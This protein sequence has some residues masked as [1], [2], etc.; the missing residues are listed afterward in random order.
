MHLRYCLRSHRQPRPD[1][2]HRMECSKGYL[3]ARRSVSNCDSMESQDVYSSGKIIQPILRRSKVFCPTC[4]I[5][6]GCRV[7]EDRRDKLT[8]S[9]IIIQGGIQWGNIGI[10]I[11]GIGIS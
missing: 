5:L 3:V 2:S 11:V 1:C 9:E 10:V 7:Q 8:G 6:S 4:E